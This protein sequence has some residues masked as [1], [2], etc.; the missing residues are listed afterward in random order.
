MGSDKFKANTKKGHKQ[1]MNKKE[2]KSGSHKT[3]PNKRKETPTQ[4][5]MVFVTR[6]KQHSNKKQK[7]KPTEKLAEAK[8]LKHEIRTGKF[9]TT[10]F[11]KTQ[12]VDLINVD[13]M[14]REL[15]KFYLKMTPK[16]SLKMM[17]K[18]GPNL[19]LKKYVIND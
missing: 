19:M 10:Q 11:Q 2:T 6:N 4:L 7:P 9:I 5:T 17:P 15:L 13:K 14:G 16:I 12:K 3:M 8:H 1:K 18:I